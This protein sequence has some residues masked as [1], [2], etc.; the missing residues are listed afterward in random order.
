MKTIRNIFIHSRSYAVEWEKPE[1]KGAF[2]RSLIF[3]IF[4]R[5]AEAL[6]S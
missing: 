2:A 1:N 3:G 5:T 4:S 6:H